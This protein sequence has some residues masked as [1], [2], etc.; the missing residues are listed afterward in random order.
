MHVLYFCQ[1]RQG[2]L[3]T[4]EHFMPHTCCWLTLLELVADVFYRYWYCHLRF[5]MIQLGVECFLSTGWRWIVN[6]LGVVLVRFFSPQ[7]HFLTMYVLYIPKLPVSTLYCFLKIH[8]VFHN[9]QNLKVSDECLVACIWNKHLY[10]K[11]KTLF[12]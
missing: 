4:E 12:T 2:L 8:C 10:S 7:W 1:L 11:N 6:I 9:V 5:W 3:L